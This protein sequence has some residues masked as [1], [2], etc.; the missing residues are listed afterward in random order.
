MV[1]AKTLKGFI[2]LPLALFRVYKQYKAKP[3]QHDNKQSKKLS[4]VKNTINLKTVGELA[5]LD[6]DKEC[7]RIKTLQSLF[8]Q[9]GKKLQSKLKVAGVMD[10]FTF[11]SY[12]PECELLALEP[13][14]LARQ[15]KTFSPD[16]VFIE[17][18]WKG[19]DDLWKTK[20]SNLSSEV[21]EL[22][23]WCR[24]N[25]VPSV[26]WN[27]EDPVHFSTFLPL[28]KLVDYVFTTD[29]DCI[30]K[31]KKEIGHERAYLLPFAAQPKKHNPIEIFE[32]KDKFCFAGSY[33]LRYPERQRDFASI[34]NACNEF[35]P[36]DIYDRNHNNPH[37]HYIFPEQYKDFIL[38][39]LPFSEIDKAYKGYN[40]GINMNTIK[41][42][43]TMFARRVY[44]LLASNTVVVSNYSRGVKS[45]FGD[46]V[47]CSDSEQEIKK[48][49]ASICS[50]EQ[51][52]KKYR[53]L[54]LRKVMLEHT[55]AHR[56]SFIA[57]VLSDKEYKSHSPNLL[58]L[59]S[60]KNGNEL[61][62]VIE[63]FG[64]Q[65][66]VNQSLVILCEEKI[67]NCSV[68]GVTLCLSHTDFIKEVKKQAEHND[69][70][71]VM[72]S[73]DFYGKQY[74]T[75]LLL[76]TNYSSYHGF[77]KKSFYLAEEKSVKL[78]SNGKQYK[79]TS[80]LMLRQAVIRL[81]EDILNYVI[82]NLSEL[83]E[84]S[85]ARP[86][87]LAIDE[88]N[89]CRNGMKHFDSSLVEEVSDT[90]LTTKGVHY[91]KNLA[92]LSKRIEPS[93]PEF[94]DSD[95][96]VTI[97]AKSFFELFEQ[98]KTSKVDISFD[99][100]KY[101]LTS[102][103]APDE[104]AYFYARKAFNRAELNLELNSLV[105]FVAY[106]NLA[107]VRTV[108]EF[109]DKSGKKISHAMPK[110]VGEQH[111]LAIPENCYFIRIGLR[112][113]GKGRLVINRVTFGAQVELPTT[114][115]GQSDTLVLTKQYP[116]Y[117]DLY[118]YGF[119]HSRIRAYRDQGTQVDVFRITNEPGWNYREFEGVDI[120]Q[121]NA[122]LLDRTLSTGQYRHVL[123]HLLDK[124]MW[125]VL[126]KYLD[127][128]KVT[129]WAHGAEI[130]LWQRR[131]FEF[132][133]MEDKEVERQ[134]RLS[135]QRK[136]FWQDVLEKPHKNLHMVFVSK[137]FRDEVFEDFGI[138]LA[139]EQYSIIPNIID[140]NV[141]PYVEK[142][143]EKRLKILSIR[144]YA[145]R[146][147]ANDLTVKAI[148]ALKDK[149]FFNELEFTL[150]GD[151]V[152][153]EEITK[154]LLG[155]KNI[156]LVRGFKSQKEIAELHKEH[157]IFLTPTRMDSQ[158]VSRDEAMS[159]GLVPITT[160]VAAIPEF[161]DN[162]C[163]YVSPAEDF[164]AMASSIEELY[165]SPEK[166]LSLSKAASARVKATLSF[167]HTI[168]K[169]LSLIMNGLGNEE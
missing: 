112:I 44:E 136:T 27:K 126:N 85:I 102:K 80:S 105:K 131:T 148:L 167:E 93:S 10:E 154:P 156:K 62:N 54:G 163:G 96:V 43:Q 68:K 150:V 159:S 97:S 157:G 51:R 160:N 38:G 53:L 17:S 24:K 39:A 124:N 21:I 66:F 41:Q 139:P 26:F 88:F 162:S 49:L 22:I 120:A 79:Q 122:A 18:A 75:D 20:V 108:F 1:N 125:Q 50:S 103:Y 74:F 114:V 32:R 132:E 138:T 116:S 31:Y 72:S 42:S 161:V 7:L 81:S 84:L 165:Y 92:L 137:Y 60:V 46:L 121:G 9:A 73:K 134:K 115:I 6:S 101:L 149:A 12:A 5:V 4:P 48:Q 78:I 55:Y 127:T 107:D 13:K 146:K 130:Q 87:M 47:V 11:H 37:P 144:P 111:S 143:P 59:A 151:G 64:R 98:P 8:K 135:D 141:F 129:I 71:S 16:F 25:N 33:Y 158:G 145:S 166:F 89:Y 36:V 15:L 99:N 77:G 35:K 94:K 133:L 83:D 128:V 153:F 117:A 82:S 140:S 155:L 123:V 164:E 100:N 45:T 63:N 29:I 2:R 70:I 14:N 67:D 119:L 104:Y 118:K 91:I 142:Q 76:A 56:L 106:S 57:S 23:E 30:A 65:S 34:I 86:T 58:V 69:F 169:E 152:L 28:A 40:F 19:K 147:Y 52:Y 90:P 3:N 95:S 168:N 110:G 113:Q 61:E 109:Q